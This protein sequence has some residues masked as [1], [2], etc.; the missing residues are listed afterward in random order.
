MSMIYTQTLPHRIQ[1]QAKTRPY[2]MPIYE[3]YC[4]PCHTIYNFFSKRI[5]TEKK[6]VCPNCTHT[7]L[8]RQVSLFSV[9]KNRQEDDD[10]LAGVDES[11]LEQA[12]VSMAGE[13]ENTDDEDPRQAARLMRKLYDAT[14]L[15]YSKNVEEAIGRMERGEDPERIEAELGDVLDDD[16]P[17]FTQSAKKLDDLRRK[18]LPPK[19]DEKLY[20]LL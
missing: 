11:K 9:S 13:V 2:E 15:Q 7:E 12:I 5:N 6:P 4:E 17:M 10:P 1:K 16:E 19:V 8:Q 14:G 18:Y 20:D 3:F